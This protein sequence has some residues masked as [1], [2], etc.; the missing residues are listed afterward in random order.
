MKLIKNIF[1][2][3]AF[4]VLL[5][6]VAAI[7]IPIF[8][9]E[10]IVEVIK[11]ETNKSLNAKVDFKDLELSLLRNFP[12]LSLHLDD[13]TVDGINEFAGV[14]LFSAPGVDLEL[15]FWKVWGNKESI[16]I[17]AFIL[18]SPKVNVLVLK[19][20]KANWDITKP[21]NDATEATEFLVEMEKYAI[22]NGQLTY[23]DES[24]N[25]Q[26][27]LNHLNHSG[28]GDF[29]EV[30]FDLNT[31][32]EIEELTVSMD[33]INYLRKAKAN[34][35]AVINLNINELIFTLKDNV[36]N[37]NNLTIKT[38]GVVDLNDEEYVIDLKFNSPQNSFKNL[39]S[40]IPAAYTADYA[41][42]KIN[43]KMTL[44]GLIKGVYNGEKG[45]YPAF[46]INTQIDN[47]SVKYPDLPM[48]LTAIF[49]NLSINSPSSDFDKM[50]IRIP[51]FEFKL[52]DNPFAGNFNL[53]TPIS[54]PKLKTELRGTLN[55]EDIQKA[56]PLEGINNLTGIIKSGFYVNAAMSQMEK[57][58]YED[59]DMRGDL[60]VIDIIIEQEEMP[61]IAIKSLKTDFSPQR[62]KFE[63][64]DAIFGQSDIRASGRI[65]NILA[66]FSPEKTMDGSFVIKSNYFNAN[67]W[68]TATTDTD[69]K[70]GFLDEGTEQTNAAKAVLTSNE[71]PTEIF[72]RFNFSVDGTIKKLNYEEYEMKD[73]S[74]QGTINPK[75]TKID[76]FYT[77]IGESD[78]RAEGN[79]NNLFGYTFDN[80]ILTGDLDIKS[81]YL[82]LNQFM[83][84]TEATEASTAVEVIPVPENVDL[85]INSDLK[86]VRYTNFDLKNIRGEVVVK[87]R[88]A[89]LKNVKGKILGGSFIFNGSYDT[90]DLN[91]PKFDMETTL[92]AMDFNNAFKT[93]NTFEKLAPI[94]KFI[95]GK[96]N[97]KLSMNGLLGKDM[98][99]D[100]STLNLKGFFHTLEG[101]VDG[102][103]PL[104]ALGNKLNIDKIKTFKIKDSKNWITVK[105]GFIEVKEFE[106]KIDDM[107]FLIKGKHSLSQQME[108]VIKA[109]IPRKLLEKTALT[110][111]A[112]KGWNFLSK[113]A[114]KKGINLANGEFV[115]LKIDLTGSFIDPKF[116]IIPVAADGET[117]VQ[118]ATKA[119]VEAAVNEAVDSVKTVVEE[120]VNEVKE[121]ATALKDT[122]TNVVEERVEE[123]KDQAKKT[124]K[125][126]AENALDSL[127]S[128][129]KIDLSKNPL[130]SIGS[131]LK[132]TT[133]GKEVDKVKDKLK[134]LF[135][136]KKKN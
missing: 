96:F 90:K 39:W 17:E 114:A 127:V 41:Q 113:E 87:E 99:P 38:E 136:K 120:T 20:G 77:K 34:L 92:S 70:L 32:T 82:D 88:S 22:K 18:E 35:E 29:S 15:D 25:F 130:D 4:L 102:F 85:K 129:G 9:K 132:D 67:E 62:I 51:Q 106:H 54:D 101:V 11:E 33:G 71:V 31:S 57:A 80:E 128:G 24:L 117:S 73:L 75:R 112:N 109:K 126:T 123:V 108:Y 30:I 69:V 116:K 43:G 28:S 66:Y 86:K 6:L 131:I 36:L 95:D 23:R 58:Q 103:K 100:F 122:V 10:E 110:A 12:A 68:I 63:D 16:P 133:L 125:E 56:I 7:A 14:R 115:N 46:K 47:G 49:A 124:A 59:I 89:F 118:D 93:F 52:G 27:V 37:I 1:K 79:V 50:V 104:Q 74:F 98:I 107:S 44:N 5:F 119:A 26:M 84:E 121:E 48:A 53:R 8:M 61:K 21:S 42:A 40:I 83:I 135:G 72:D 134:D 81:N 94:G 2:I 19:D 105:N 3:L 60:E 91:K 45:I 55:L 76:K 78:I 97:T 64:F 13:L 111:A 65:F